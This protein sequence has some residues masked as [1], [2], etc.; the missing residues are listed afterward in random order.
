M[1]TN[2]FAAK[3][4]NRDQLA[5]E[6]AAL[7]P[8]LNEATEAWLDARKVYGDESPEE[9]AIWP[10]LNSLECDKARILTIAYTLDKIDGLA[11]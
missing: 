4:A 8:R 7:Q 3:G 1:M 2:R 6:L 9:H 10:L 11:A 5:R